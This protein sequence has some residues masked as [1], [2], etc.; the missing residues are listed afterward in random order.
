MT[1]ASTMYQRSARTFPAELGAAREARRFVGD[2]LAHWGCPELATAA[3]LMV[4]E[5]FTNA[6]LHGC[7]DPQVVITLRGDRMEVQVHDDD[8]SPPV[9]R[10]AGPQD[11]SG[12]G[13]QIVDSL[14]EEWG[15]VPYGQGKY[16]WCSLDRS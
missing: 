1:E 16:V 10:S 12:R 15:S 4:S 9:Q 7:G 6:V 14:S 13:L 8:T 2:T 3:V 11:T 5:M